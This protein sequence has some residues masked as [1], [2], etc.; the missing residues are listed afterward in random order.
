MHHIVAERGGHA[1][2]DTDQ[3]II[4]S[5]GKFNITLSDGIRTKTYEM[6]DATRGLYVP[7]KIFIK[8]YDCSPDAVCLVLANKHYDIS[9]SIRSWEDYKARIIKEKLI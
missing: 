3:V 9:K 2:I 8:I 4:A 7:R 1:H 6:N 5:S